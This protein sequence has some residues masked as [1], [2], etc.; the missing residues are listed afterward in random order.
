M[1]LARN[2][3]EVQLLSGYGVDAYKD[4][5]SAAGLGPTFLSALLQGLVFFALR[6]LLNRGLIRKVW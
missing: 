2:N 1:E 4:P 6:L 5:F 3:M